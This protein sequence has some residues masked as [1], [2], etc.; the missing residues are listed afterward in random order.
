MEGLLLK[1]YGQAEKKLG[2]GSYSNVYKHG[3]YA[4]KSFHDEDNILCCTIRE[5]AI[6]KFLASNP[7]IVGWVDLF[8]EGC[9]TCAV[10]ELAECTLFQYLQFTENS[11]SKKQIY[12]LIETLSYVHSMGVTHRD[13][14]SANI[15][16][17]P[18]GLKLA[19]FGLAKL[20]SFTTDSGN[21]DEVTTLCYRAPEIFME[22]IYDH[23]IDI[24]SLGCVIAEI[25][26]RKLIF[27]AYKMEEILD[28]FWREFGDY[29]LVFSKLREPKDKWIEIKKGLLT[30][31]TFEPILQGLPIVHRFLKIDPSK[32]DLLE[33]ILEDPYFSDCHED[34]L[35]P[36][37]TQR[38]LVVKLDRSFTRP[39]NL[40]PSPFFHIL[41]YRKDVSISSIMLAFHL[42]ETLW[43]V[44]EDKDLVGRVCIYISS[45]FKDVI[46]LN[47]F[48]L[49]K[50]GSKLIQ[51]A[52]TKLEV[53]IL[54]SLD[55]NLCQ[56]TSADY[57]FST[58][59]VGINIL[60]MAGEI[61]PLLHLANLHLPLNKREEAESAVMFILGGT[62]TYIQNLKNSNLNVE[63]D[64]LTITIDELKSVIKTMIEKL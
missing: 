63:I 15:L 8:I 51:S 20:S 58:S 34:I 31:S 56:V 5:I 49:N 62:N 26:L 27:N 48:D 10:M 21:T 9:N 29:T 22:E 4:I 59:L 32:R 16:V 19:D 36:P 50:K 39:T 38:E 18:T 61:L 30:R 12:N 13:I 23:R 14:K 11:I 24:W 2:S 28:L 6:V 37:K 7:N 47:H 17:Y 57:L 33:D 45:K 60:K 42:L 53:K 46:Q 54:K 35:L 25:Y 41:K 64:H 3:K 44:E 52:W 1:K 40:N 43:S 55:F